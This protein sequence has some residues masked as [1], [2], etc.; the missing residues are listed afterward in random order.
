MGGKPVKRLSILIA[1]FSLALIVSPA[2]AAPK[3]DARDSDVGKKLWNFNV[4]A[5]PN[6]W[7]ASS[8]TC[9][10]NGNRIFF[11]Q[12]SNGSTLGTITW[13]FDP[14]ANQS[15]NITDCNGTIDGDADVVVDESMQV[16]VMIKLV[17]PK[18]SSLNVVCT[19]V[20]DY[21]GVDDLCLIGSANINRNS[22]TKIMSN[23]A[24]GQY[25]EVLWS[26]SGSWKVFQVQ[27]YEK[28]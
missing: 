23:I 12:G 5:K 15:F 3:G 11:K 24:E 16:Y 13:H 22:T 27:I 7:V 21:L 9:P 2:M 20:I 19:D 14:A 18:T 10:N 4:L 26:L 17:G 1:L 8:T 25:E 28:L 6:A